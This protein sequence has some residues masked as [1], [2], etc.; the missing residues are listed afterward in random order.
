MRVSPSGAAR[1]RRA[2]ILVAAVGATACG[3]NLPGD[4]GP[5]DAYLARCTVPRA[6]ASAVTG[7]DFPDVPGTVDDEKR[8]VRAWIDELY[9]WYREV[10]DPDA[11]DYADPISYFDVLKTPATTTSGA[12]K[13]RFHFTYPTDAWEA[14]SLRGVEPSYGV[15]WAI[16]AAQPPRRVIAAY[17][18]PGS[19]AAAASVGRGVEV[20]S[21]DGVDLINGSDVAALN[22]GL[23]PAGVGETHTFEVL[24]AGAAAPRTVSLTSTTVE[25]AP[26]QN[27][28]VVE[29]PTG[30][31]GY[32]TFTDHI[33]TAESELVDAIGQ[34]AAG[35]GVSDLVLDL[36]YNGGG[37][38]A[39]ASQVAYM[40]AGPKRTDGKTFERIVF[41][42]KYPSRNPVTG[43]PLTPVPFI[44]TTLGFSTTANQPLPGLGLRR[45]FV[46]TGPGTCSAS[47]SLVNGLRGIDVEV[48]QIGATT[49]GKPF[50]FYP[51]DDCGTTY[52]SIQ[53]QGV[54]AKGFGDYTDGFVPGSAEPAGI[55]GCVVADDFSRALGD[56]AE[57]R[58]QAALAYRESGACPPAA[59]LSRAVDAP[60]SAV[61]GDIVKSPWHMNRF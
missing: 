39:I 16:V 61:D 32:L 43:Q 37:Y 12:P 55:P 34:L 23:L 44:D 20:L 18:Q 53:F 59:S 10:P 36:R 47:E 42:D 13:D 19:P 4:D 58:F 9:L 46:L 2:A 5:S 52:F 49:C 6:G 25:I 15:T 40:I 33:A 51:Q 7:E 41:N 48:I 11:D 35:G 45:V 17:N 30:R 27:V 28:S 54:N 8:W 1:I 26:V 3:D 31:V 22:A 57:A 24:D 14:L 29:T 50:G 38:V 21:V 56:P 60:L